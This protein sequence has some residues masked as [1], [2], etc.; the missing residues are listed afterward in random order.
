MAHSGPPAKGTKIGRTPTADW[1]EVPNE[2]FAG[3]WPVDLPPK[4][5][6]AKWNPMVEQ[7]WKIVRTM[8]HC[9][10]WELSDWLFAVETAYLKQELWSA[11]GGEDGTKTTAWTELRRRE[12][13]MGTTAEERRKLRIRY[14][15]QRP[16]V[17]GD[18]GQ[19]DDDPEVVV[20]DRPAA[21]R[22]NVTPIES[23]RS[24][25]TRAG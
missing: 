21:R 14:V 22:G 3:P 16:Q 23:R 24:R 13:L 6:R 9:T 15:D 2:P 10:L 17:E 25:L 7:W 20:E 8:P 19:P 4:C 11:Y 1:I 5:G 18:D 12:G